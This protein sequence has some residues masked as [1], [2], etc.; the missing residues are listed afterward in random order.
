MK[1]CSATSAVREYPKER[2]S[3]GGIGKTETFIPLR[4]TENGADILKN[5]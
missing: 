2:T 3:V 4:E 1:K 5:N